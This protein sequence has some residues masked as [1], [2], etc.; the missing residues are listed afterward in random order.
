MRQRQYAGSYLDNILQV[1]C[2]VIKISIE[3]PV[4]ALLN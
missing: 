3:A 4:D 1:Y 2:S